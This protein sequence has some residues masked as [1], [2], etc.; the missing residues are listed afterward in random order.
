MKGFLTALLL[1][2]GGVTISAGEFFPVRVNQHY[3]CVNSEGKMV[4]PPVYK[5]ITNGG[6]PWSW[7]NHWD[8]FLNYALVQNDSDKFGVINSRGEIVTPCVYDRIDNDAFQDDRYIEVETNK[9]KGI[10]DTNGRTILPCVYTYLGYGYNS[11][12]TFSQTSGP[13]KKLGLLDSMGRIV[14][15]EKYDD[16]LA[17]YDDYAEV[18]IGNKRGFITYADSALT[19][20]DMD[21][22]GINDYTK[23]GKKGLFN[24][25]GR[26]LTPPRYDEINALSASCIIYKLRG[27]F[28][29]LDST[30]APR[31]PP[32]YDDYYA[33]TYGFPIAVKKNGK[34]SLVNEHLQVLLPFE[35]ENAYKDIVMDYNG[36]RFSIYRNKKA[37]LYSF[38]MKEYLPCIYDTLVG[39]KGYYK[40]RLSGQWGIADTMGVM[41]VQPAYDD[42]ITVYDHKLLAE[43]NGKLGVAGFNG[44]VIIPFAYD[45]PEPGSGIQADSVLVLRKNEKCVVFDWNGA[46]IYAAQYPYLH[47]HPKSN[48]IT[49]YT[50]YPLPEGA[51]ATGPYNLVFGLIEMKHNNVIAE[52]KYNAIEHVFGNGAAIIYYNEQGGR[53]GVYGYV[54]PTGKETLFLN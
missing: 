7:P 46:C 9:L 1:A 18:Q 13:G 3:G 26:L 43:K 38:D 21:E 4:I 40:V 29:F 48:R 15:N 34:W 53:Y 37:G 44:N 50:E 11:Y 39:F 49:T 23:G 35:F 20:V 24:A 33:Y 51:M 32:A 2:S 31:I 42:I 36:R 10:I 28:G 5:S 30:G 14:V 6:D 19:P 12:R 27:K 25:R 17:I 22:I 45:D 41:Q 47:V 16:I 8:P 54:S 52:P